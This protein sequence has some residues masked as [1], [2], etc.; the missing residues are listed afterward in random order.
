VLVV[1][2]TGFGLGVLTAYAQE[3]LPEHLKYPIDFKQTHIQRL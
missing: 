2:L 1:G 3:W